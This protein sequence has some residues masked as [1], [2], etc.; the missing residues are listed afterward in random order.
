M[1]LQEAYEC[2]GLPRSAGAAEVK[3]A[4][5]ARIREAHPDQGGDAST[6]IKVRAAYEILSAVLHEPVVEDEVP[7]P[8]GLRSVIDGLVRAF[9]EQQ[10]WAQ[11]ETQRQMDLFET[12]MTEHIQSASRRDL[13]Q[14]SGTFK[15]SWDASINALFLRCNKRCDSVIQEYETWYTSSTQAIFDEMYRK[16]L[17]NFARSRRFWEVFLIAAVLGVA[18]GWAFGWG[19]AL[20]RWLSVALALVA[21]G[22]AFLAH[23]W[24][25]RRQRRIREKVEPLSVVPFQIQEGAR[26]ETEAAL[27]Q[28]RKAT[29]ALSVTG[30]MV[31]NAISGGLAAP[32]MGAVAG[33]AL[34]GGFDR[35]LNPTKRMRQSMLVEL[36]LF[37]QAA[38]P[39]VTLYVLQAHERLLSEVQEQIV[40][41]YEERVKGTVHL[42]TAGSGAGSRAASPSPDL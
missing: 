12:R 25:A 37:M 1:T 20:G 10:Q 13:R 26:F 35:L 2:L 42:L 11:D 39:Q 32:V 8:P 15:N 38:R 6:F 7:I 21:F 33:A 3:A 31:G 40:N 24:V 28:G 19:S 23:R 14:F 29:A 16:E 18:L 4:Y 36:R 5:R 9:R 30:M 34:G 17:L 22:L 27:R 41:N